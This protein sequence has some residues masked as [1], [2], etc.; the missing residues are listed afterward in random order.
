MPTRTRLVCP[1]TRREMEAD[2]DGHRL[3]GGGA[4]LRRP[5][6]RL[7]RQARPARLAA[8][9]LLRGVPGARPAVAGPRAWGRADRGGRGLLRQRERAVRDQRALPPRYLD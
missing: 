2:G 1:E 3:P 9:A 5:A 6:R 4:A 8:P 7:L